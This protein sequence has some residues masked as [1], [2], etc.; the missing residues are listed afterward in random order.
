M[1]R[2]KRTPR[3]WCVVLETTFIRNNKKESNE[4]QTNHIYPKHARHDLE[5]FRKY[6][7]QISKV[8][9]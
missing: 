3:S 7:L 8:S 9:V 1:V 5:S 6:T 2:I 4:R